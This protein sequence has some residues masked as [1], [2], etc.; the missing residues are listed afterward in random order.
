MELIFKLPKD[1]PPF[2]GILFDN[3][4]IACTLNQ[5]LL[6]QEGAEFNVMFDLLANNLSL[7][8]IG[9]NPSS[10]YIYHDLKYDKDKFKQWL[11]YVKPDTRLNF[12][13]LL[14]VKERH[15]VVTTIR[16][17]KLFILKI[18]SYFMLVQ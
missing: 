13:H 17:R 5:E 14:M 9:N 8:L 7:R 1:K 16:E 10:F 18:E 11:H 4:H 3:V 15:T 12:S 6:D 2:L